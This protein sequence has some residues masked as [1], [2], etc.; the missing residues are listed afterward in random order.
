M[1]NLQAGSLYT[2]GREAE[3]H[4]ETVLRMG[5]LGLPIIKML[6]VTG[7]AD[8]IV[9]A[10]EK[11]GAQR[12]DLEYD[13]DGVVIKT[14]KLSYRELLGENTNTPKWAVAY[15]FP[16]EQKETKLLDIALQV[17]RTGVITPNAVL[18]PVRLA[19][20]SVSR[21]TPIE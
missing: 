3:T 12:D 10:I 21:A 1:F 4:E 13:I 20:T 6:A 2:D 14:N 11:L 9:S 7:E 19:G 15:K 5:E 18:E 17:G 16:P 8:E